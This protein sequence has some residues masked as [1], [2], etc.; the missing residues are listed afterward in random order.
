MDH[1]CKFN[2]SAYNSHA[3]HMPQTKKEIEV[4]EKADLTGKRCGSISIHLLRSQFVWTNLDIKRQSYLKHYAALFTCFSSQA[5][6]IKISNTIDADSFIMALH[7]FLAK[8]GSVQSIWSDNGINLVGANNELQKAMKEMDHL[9][10]KN[11]L[12]GNGNDWI[13]WHKNPPGTSHIG[14]VWEC[15]ENSKRYLR[16]IAKNTWSVIK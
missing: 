3:C 9:K 10:I 6:H 14:V 8:R 15:Q 1:Q 16:R 4:S 11:F 12:L 7:R 2:G 5:V 13:L